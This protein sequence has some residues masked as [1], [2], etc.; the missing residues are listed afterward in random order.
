M[1]KGLGSVPL[2]VEGREEGK[3]KEKRYFMLLKL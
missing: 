2:Q 1:L 3:R